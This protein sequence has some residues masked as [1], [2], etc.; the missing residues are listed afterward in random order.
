[1]SLIK[2]FS[3]DGVLFCVFEMNGIVYCKPMRRKKA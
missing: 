3:K 1:M 2:E